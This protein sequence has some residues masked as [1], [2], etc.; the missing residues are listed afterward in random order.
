MLPNATAEEGHTVYVRIGRVSRRLW[1]SAPLVCKESTRHATRFGPAEDWSLC[2]LKVLS[3]VDNESMTFTQND[4]NNL[5]IWCDMIRHTYV[6]LHN[7]PDPNRWYHTQV[8]QMNTESEHKLDGSALG[9]GPAPWII[10]LTWRYPEGAGLIHGL[11]LLRLEVSPSALGCPWTRPAA[12]QIA[13]L[14]SL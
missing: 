1:L 8:A 5:Y 2:F 11:D 12:R 4:D 9:P 14:G 6:V 13:R 10:V 3:H 7:Y